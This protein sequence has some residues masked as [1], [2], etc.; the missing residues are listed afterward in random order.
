MRISLISGPNLNLLGTR[1]PEHYG[2]WSLD[3][4]EMACKE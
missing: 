1:S 2:D 3:Q 4:L